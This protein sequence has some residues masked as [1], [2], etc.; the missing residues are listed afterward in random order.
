MGRHPEGISQGWRD[1]PDKSFKSRTFETSRETQTQSSA[2]ASR[3]TIPWD[4]RGG[5]WMS[6]HRSRWTQTQDWK[7]ATEL[8]VETNHNNS[9]QDGKR[10][11]QFFLDRYLLWMSR[12]FAEDPSVRATDLSGQSLRGWECCQRT[13]RSVSF[14]LL[15]PCHG[16]SSL[17]CEHG[18]CS[19][20][21]TG[22]GS[23]PLF[24]P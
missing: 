10:K 4:T 9:P 13:P 18:T 14:R 15:P 3:G 2:R 5:K 12:F 22:C 23:L 11:S 8:D 19:P 7:N 21:R 17:R 24:P 1:A 16:T 20:R 6:G